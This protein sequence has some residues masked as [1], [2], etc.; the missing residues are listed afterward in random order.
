MD[1]VDLQILI[2]SSMREMEVAVVAG[3][4]ELGAFVEQ[5]LGLR[6]LGLFVGDVVAVGM[7]AGDVVEEDAV[8]AMVGAELVLEV[9]QREVEHMG[10]TDYVEE[11]DSHAV[12][13]AAAVAGMENGA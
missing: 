13:V 11:A 12:G 3:E 4:E 9:E 7:L 6:K 1:S 10:D 5:G 8:C 2:S